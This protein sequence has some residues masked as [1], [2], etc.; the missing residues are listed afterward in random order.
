MTDQSKSHLTIVFLTVFLYLVGFGVM[1]PVLPVLSREYG[2][3]AFEVGLMMSVY[4]F[5]QF[6]FSPFWGRLSD[7]KGRRPILLFC[8]LG[9]AFSYLLFTLSHSLEMLFVAR[10][11][12]GFFGAS[13][14]TASAAISDVTPA[15]ERSKGMALIGAA[16]GLGFIVGPGLGGAL[17]WW[18]QTLRPDQ[19]QFGMQ[20]A[21]A[22]VAVICAL[23]FVFAFFKLKESRV[24]SQVPLEVTTR[25]QKLGKFLRRPVAGPLIGS[26][27]LNSLAMSMMEA[28]LILFVADRF[29]WGLREVSFGFAYIGVLSAFSQGFLVRKLLP[30]LGERKLMRTGILLMAASFFLIVVA[31]QI[32]I[33]A[34]S[35]TLLSFGTSFSNPS[36]LGSISLLSSK[37]EQGEALGTTQGT[38]SLGRILGPAMGGFL[39]GQVH[40]TSPFLGACV[41]SLTSFVIVLM[42]GTRVPDSAL[43]KKA[44]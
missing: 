6:L 40:V 36:L 33:L 38:A 18:G 2:A 20:F 5:M 8:L 19:P 34:I 17:A 11:L 30:K 7:R 32:W 14:S 27:F 28:T 3:T 37:D 35:M 39:Y 1:I 44:I 16:F 9:E 21:A 12:A 43:Q 13:I 4:S 22:S 29:G 23:T 42:Q 24:F 31:S 25:W 41:F 10:A 26:F 15:H